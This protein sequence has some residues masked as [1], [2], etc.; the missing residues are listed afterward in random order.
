MTG[1][2]RPVSGSPPPTPRRIPALLLGVVACAALGACQTIS[3]D[4]G[5]QVLRARDAQS[6]PPGADPDSCY[7]RTVTPAI[8]ESVTEQVLVQPPQIGSDGSISY[9]AVYRTETR[10]EIVRERHELWFETLCDEELTLEFIASVQRALAARNYFS[11]TA[12]G[13]MDRPT[14]AAIRAYQKDQGVD[15][16]VLSLAAARKLGLKAVARTR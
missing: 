10:Q 11:G 5:T 14:R 2:P 16:E 1:H 9:P 6:A 13:R 3:P 12:T 7:G 8:I 4:T 15:S